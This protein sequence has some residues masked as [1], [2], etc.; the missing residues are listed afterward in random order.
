MTELDIE[1]VKQSISL[2]HLG[3]NCLEVGT[4]EDWCCHR[5]L[6]ESYGISVTGIDIKSGNYVDHVVDLEENLKKI[7]TA[8]TGKFPFDSILCLNVLEHTFIHM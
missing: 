7:Q 8:L 1:Y 6:L 4:A 5:P 3:T 2:D